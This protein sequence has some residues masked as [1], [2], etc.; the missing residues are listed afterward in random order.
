MTSPNRPQNDASD[1]SDALPISDLPAAEQAGD[2]VVGGELRYQTNMQ[3]ENQI[4][5]AV[6]NVMKTNQ[7]TVKN[8]IGNVK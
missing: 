3:T 4:F 8:S 2:Q 1:P 6:S 7:D 5:T